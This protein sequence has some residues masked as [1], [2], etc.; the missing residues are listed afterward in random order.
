MQSDLHISE[1]DEENTQE[2]EVS[3]L[4]RRFNPDG[5]KNQNN[6]KIV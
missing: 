5:K 6:V 2:L 3:S 4:R 1:N